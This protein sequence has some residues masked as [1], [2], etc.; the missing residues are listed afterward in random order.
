MVLRNQKGA[1]L[2]MKKLILSIFTFF[3]IIMA[4][5][6]GFICPEGEAGAGAG[7]DGGAGNNGE[8]GQ[9]DAGTGEGSNADGEKDLPE[10]IKKE[11]KKLRE[12]NASRRVKN[13]TLEDRLNKLESGLKGVFGGEQEEEG[14]QGDAESLANNL[15]TIAFENAALNIALENGV[16][17]DKVKYLKY[18]LTEA[19]A[20]LGDDE[21]L[22]EEILA[23]IIQEVKGTG[24]G[25]AT[26]T[27]EEGKQKPAAGEEDS[28]Q[29]DYSKTTAAEFVKLGESEKNKMFLTDRASYDRLYR[30]AREKKLFR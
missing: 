27:P 6:G 9:G 20:N 30:E 3:A 17:R 26:T 24:K 29:K 15:N 25:K 12:E 22:P 5:N 18:R 14:G 4:S 13:K 11:L 19:A 16:P 21:E 28:Q 8:G 10:A 1:S 23:E 2:I 7:D